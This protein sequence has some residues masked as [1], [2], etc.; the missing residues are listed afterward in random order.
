MPSLKDVIFT[1]ILEPFHGVDQET[2]IYPT[3]EKKENCSTHLEP[4]KGR[5]KV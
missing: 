3:E 4:T 2:K 1:N 5:K